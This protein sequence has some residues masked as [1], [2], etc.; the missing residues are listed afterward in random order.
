V[1]A[2][3]ATVI[4]LA[5]RPSTWRRT[6]RKA[7]ATQ[8]VFAGVGAAGFTAGVGFLVGLIVVVQAQFWLHRVGQ[9]EYLG[10]LLVAVV[11]R[12]IGP[13][14]A[15]LIVIGR[16]GSGTAVEL[17]H[18][19]VTGEVHA[20]DAL[21]LDPF[22]YLVLPRTLGI[23]IAIFCLSILLI[24]VSLLG[25]YTCAAVL[26]TGSGTLPDF[27]YAVARSIRGVDVLNVLLKT[28]LPGL[29]AGAIC[30]IEGLRADSAAEIAW[31]G[32]RG[33]QR[34]VTVLFVVSAVLSLFTYL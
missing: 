27:L 33:V 25:G 13:L 15:N 22:L 14:L 31:A 24:V 9:S 11:I 16:S 28:L 5:A 26:G 2:T 20:L 17:A 12:E 7:L 32:S 23:C 8:I 30:C 3:A 18:M 19:R 1:A 6:V 4:L 29:L 21:G 34:S 10:P